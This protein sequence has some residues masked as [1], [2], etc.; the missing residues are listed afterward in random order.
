M[1]DFLVGCVSRYREL[2]GEKELRNVA[3]PFL[4]ESREPVKIHQQGKDRKIVEEP[5]IV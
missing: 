4:D 3:T 1:E 2:S 5:P